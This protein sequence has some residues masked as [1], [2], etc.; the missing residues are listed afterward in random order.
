M[1]SI[2]A[3][4]I[5]SFA[6]AAPAVAL[7]AGAP[8][9]GVQVAA[10]PVM[11]AA[12]SARVVDAKTNVPLADVKVTAYPQGST[13]AESTT[14]TDS[15]GQFTLTGLRGGEYRLLFERSGYP[16][17]LAGG[18]GVKPHDH[19]VLISSFA[20]Q[21]KTRLDKARLVDP[22][23]SLVQ[24]GQVADVYVICSGH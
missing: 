3:T 10:Q 13:V 7:S 18:I 4:L 1:K 21:S 23:G 15:Q 19:L 16:R 5:L 12:L 14:M 9:S 20:L 17:S 11:F 6:I 24:P 22:C 8:S 2:I